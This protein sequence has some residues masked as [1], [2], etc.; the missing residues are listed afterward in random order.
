NF[1]AL[2][3]WSEGS[4]KEIYSL[5]ELVEAFDLA[6]VNRAGAKF[7]PEKNKWFNHQYLVQKSNEELAVFLKPVLEEKGLTVPNETIVKV[8]GLVKERA[9]LT[10]DLF[11]LDRKSTR[12]N[13][14]H[15]KISYAV[16]CL[17]KKKH[18]QEKRR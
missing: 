5:N 15:V 18:T 4:D 16:F 8:V 6:R 17:K 13:S 12:L 9:N 10:T 1:L 3:G 14:S 11:E 7:D 2:L